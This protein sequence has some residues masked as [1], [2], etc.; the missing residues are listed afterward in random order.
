MNEQNI[1]LADALRHNDAYDA[2]AVEALYREAL[3]K[4]SRKVVVFDD[5]PTGIQTTHDVYVYT[6]WDVETL[7]EAFLDPYPMFYIL[8]NSRALTA[9]ET[10]ALHKEAA[11]NLIE[12]SNRTGRPFTAMLRGDSTLRGHFPLETETIKNVFTEHGIRVDGEILIP[13]FPEGGRYTFNDV[14]YLTQDG[15]T[16]IP[17]GNS[18]FARD[19]T[20]GYRSSNLPEWVEEKSNGRFPKE[21]VASVSIEELSGLRIR[22]IREK[23]EGLTDF[24]KLIV[25]CTS[26]TDLKVFMTAFIEALEIGKNYLMRTASSATKVLGGIPDRPLLSKEELT[27]VNDTGVIVIG[28]HTKRTTDQLWRLKERFPELEYIEFD[29][30]G[31]LTPERFRAAWQEVSD[32][33]TDAVR[34]GKTSVIY[35]TREDFTVDTGD[36]EDEL[37]AAV[38]IS[39]AVTSFIEELPVQPGFIIAKGGITSSGIGT[40]ALHVRR[41]LALGQILPGV[42]VWQLGPESR[43][44]GTSFIIFPGN[45]GTEDALADAVAILKQ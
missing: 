43:F 11:E 17:V 31:V 12:A 3:A 29:V 14:H 26:Y 10:E 6:R 22:E 42:P 40:K 38:T 28:S 15:K 4:L 39:D 24:Q 37:R 25:N 36:P 5:D 20:F 21:S 33:L 30:T 19:W 8:T 45:V 27:G 18:E 41:A 23:L 34:K 35:T 7:T 32:R 16:L 1:L 9:K 2:G 44:E 13:F